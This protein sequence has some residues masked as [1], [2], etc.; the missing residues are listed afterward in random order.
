MEG[1]SDTIPKSKNSQKDTH[2]ESPIVNEIVDVPVLNHRPRVVN[3]DKDIHG[4]D[5]QAILEEVFLVAE[6]HT[7]SNPVAVVI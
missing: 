4:Y 7:V 5:I 1:K 6:S 3:D 2:V